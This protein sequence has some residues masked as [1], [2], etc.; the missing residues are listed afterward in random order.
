M[1]IMMD[2]N[3]NHADPWQETYAKTMAAFWTKEGLSSYGGKYTLGGTKRDSVHYTG[4]VAVNGML[5]FAL[6]AADG[7]PF[8][9]A[10]WDAAIPASN[11]DRYYS[12]CLYMLSMLHMSGK[13]NL[14]YK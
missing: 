2:Y 6:P 3:L 12:G 9:Q 4:T 8:L 7:K 11:Q 14:F 1:N 5:A 10:V 13:F